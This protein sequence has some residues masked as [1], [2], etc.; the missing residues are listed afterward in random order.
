MEEQ[1]F[2]LITFYQGWETYQQSLVE[3]V[4]RLS[5]EQLA[6]PTT[7]HHWSIGMLLS[8]MIS[9]RVAWFHLRMGEGNPDL[10]HWNEDGQPVRETAELVAG[11][12]ATWHM[13]AA[14]LARWTPADLGHLFPT[15]ALGWKMMV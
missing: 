13:I 1:A 9:A 4:A 8:H 14:A 3:T 5:S 7:P 15:P 2:P 11:F 12:E 6:F 10:V